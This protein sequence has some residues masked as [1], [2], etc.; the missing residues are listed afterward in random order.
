[1]KGFIKKIILIL[2]TIA[3][4]A[5]FCS[6]FTACQSKMTGK[7][8]DTYDYFNTTTTLVLYDDFSDDYQV[9]KAD[10]V[11]K[12]IK[13]KLSA[14]EKAI[15]VDKE[16]SDIF[17]FNN[18]LGG[19]LE[20]REETYSLL[21]F[22][23]EAYSTTEGAFNPSLGLYVDLWGFSPRFSKVDYQATLAYDRQDYKKN[24]PSQEYIE[25]FAS[26]IDFSKVKI[27]INEGKYY[28]YKPADYVTINDVQY[29]MNINLGGVGKGYAV[30]MVSSYLEE[31]GFYSGYVSIGR[32]SLFLLDNAIKIKGAPSEKD[33]KVGLV[34]PYDTEKQYADL[35]LNN[36]CLSTSGN[37]EN[38]YE[39][40][41]KRYCHIIDS[42]T[43]C[44]IDN[45]ITSV[46]AVSKSAKASDML[47][48][49]L[50]S[51]GIDKAKE[52]ANTLKPLYE[53]IIT[54]K[55]GD[56]FEAYVSTDK[57]N[58]VLT[59]DTFKIIMSEALL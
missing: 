34:N 13:D 57:N 29:T 4:S 7:Q 30:D 19:W 31:Q 33:W 20:I 44:P 52:Q 39:I 1:M 35:F 3:V 47:T 26:L 56:D 23:Q 36:T 28:V 38:F 51:M 9:F 16:G 22:C 12:D 54:Y 53:F 2:I 32:S 42:K 45:T 8:Y 11:W 15:S 21:N 46:T 25:G 37:Y 10:K 43:L 58:F 17:K 49:A 6:V 50:C 40:D 24:L 48:T 18:S 14:I 55:K 27:K 59:D 41:G 5:T